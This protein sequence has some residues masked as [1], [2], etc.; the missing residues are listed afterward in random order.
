MGRK[1][2]YHIN[3]TDEEVNKLK[4]TIKR[5]K[6]SR[7]VC[8]RCQILLDL[9]EAHG[10]VL[11]HRQSARSSGVCEAT[12]AAVVLRYATGGVDEV[13]KYKRNPNSDNTGRK[14]D[15]R[16]EAKIIQ[17]ACGP[18]PE[19][20]ARWTLRLL[21]KELKLELEVPVGKDAIRRTL[22][23]TTLSR[24]AKTIGA[25]PKKGMLNL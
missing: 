4:S 13:I 6:T 10:E 5:K 3:L 17:V 25:S 24:T 2:K 9:D 12:V 7:S 19:G 18:V 11:T 1:K 22:K 8:R 23:K 15:G 21:E 14:V 20:H 16:A